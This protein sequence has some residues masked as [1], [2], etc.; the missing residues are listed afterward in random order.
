MRHSRVNLQRSARFMDIL[1]FIRFDDLKF[2]MDL[3]SCFPYFMTC[4]R[5]H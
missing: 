2:E 5:T 4:H 3:F 1:I